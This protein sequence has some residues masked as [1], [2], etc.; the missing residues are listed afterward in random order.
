MK[1]KKIH[2][3]IV[4]IWNGMFLF[5]GT[6]IDTAF[7]QHNAVQLVLGLDGAFTIETKSTDSRIVKANAIVEQ[8]D[9]KKGLCT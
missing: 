4:Y 1:K 8:M 2:D 6:V 3:G 7:H 9:D 5:L